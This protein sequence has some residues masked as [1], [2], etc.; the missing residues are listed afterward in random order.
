[1]KTPLLCTKQ[2]TERKR[3]IAKAS[4][5]DPVHFGAL[6]GQAARV[7]EDSR[8]SKSHAKFC[9]LASVLSRC[10]NTLSRFMFSFLLLEDSLPQTDSALALRCK[11]TGCTPV[12]VERF[13]LL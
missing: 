8:Y 12:R 9:A 3:R 11:E 6:R 7:K 5:S 2:W 1:M 4:D 10:R 13:E